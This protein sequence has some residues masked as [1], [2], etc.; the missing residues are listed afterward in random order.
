MAWIRVTPLL[1]LV[2]LALPVTAT[3]APTDRWVG[4]DKWIHG[5]MSA[6]IA[7][8]AFLTTDALAPEK[9]R[10]Y[11]P[12]TVAVGGTFLIG[13]GKE[14]VDA[15]NGKPFSGKDLVWDLGGTLLGTGISWL[16]VFLLSQ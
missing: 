3:G 10:A 16:V 8:L 4:R 5:A 6:S 13:L 15:M 9:Q 12:V 11:L 14:G 1:F 7:Q 2:V